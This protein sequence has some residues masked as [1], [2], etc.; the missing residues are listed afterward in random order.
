MSRS[1]TMPTSRSLSAT[2]SAPTSVCAMI[3][4]ACCAVSFGFTVLTSWL[5]I[6]LIFMAALPCLQFTCTAN[7]SRRPWFLTG[8]SCDEQV[9]RLRSL[10]SSLLSLLPLNAPQVPHEVAPALDHVVSDARRQGRGVA[11]QQRVQHMLV[12]VPAVIGRMTMRVEFGQQRPDLY[13]HG[14]QEPDQLRHARAPVDAEM[15]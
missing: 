7:S 8:A 13:P 3:S 5:M 12:L 9:Q 14:L 10:G 2:G 11:L 4:A 1:V 15:E 6:S